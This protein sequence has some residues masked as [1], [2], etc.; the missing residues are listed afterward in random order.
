MDKVQKEKFINYIKKLEIDDN[1]YGS[2]EKLDQYE[3][4][5]Y[6]SADVIQFFIV[7]MI[8][9][10]GDV[11]LAKDFRKAWHYILGSIDMHDNDLLHYRTTNE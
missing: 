6:R 1:E 7:D 5:L 10:D 3:K 2:W 11:H 4:L 9:R 8:A